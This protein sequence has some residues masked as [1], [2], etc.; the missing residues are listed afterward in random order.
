MTSPRTSNFFHYNIIHQQ[1]LPSHVI[2]HHKYR[3]HGTFF[4]M[5]TS[6]QRQKVPI[7]S[8]RN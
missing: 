6:T 8:I 4:I 3:S 7:K 1:H 2:S 5:T